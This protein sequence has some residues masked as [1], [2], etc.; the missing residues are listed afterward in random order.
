MKVNENEQVK[1]QMSPII[2]EN[3]D[4]TSDDLTQLALA[5]D[6]S[7][8]AAAQVGVMTDF[9]DYPGGPAFWMAV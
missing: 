3:G 9:R 2:G 8:F 6:P 5:A 4:P 7:F 1:I